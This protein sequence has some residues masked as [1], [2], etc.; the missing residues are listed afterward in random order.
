MPSAPVGAT[1]EGEEEEEEE[2]DCMAV[3]RREGVVH[4]CLFSYAY[5]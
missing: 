1:E 2:F 3:M 4:L 5:F